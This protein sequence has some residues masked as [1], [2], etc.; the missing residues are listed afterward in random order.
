LKNRLNRR[1]AEPVIALLRA[2]LAPR[3]LAL[4][5]AIAAPLRSH[6]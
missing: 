1:L 4:S 2:G 6:P 5:I 3:R